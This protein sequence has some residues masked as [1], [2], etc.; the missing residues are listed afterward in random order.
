MNGISVSVIIAT[1]NTAE[2]LDECLKSIVIQTL[3]DIEVI[4]V[5]DGSTDN[6]KEIIDTYLKK[7]RNF[8]YMYKENAGAGLARNDGIKIAQGEYL[9]F[10]DPDDKYPN[11]ESLEKL[12]RMAKLKNADICGGN[13]ISFNDSKKWVCYKAGDGSDKEITD[14]VI[15]AK[16]YKY[17]YG[18]QRYFYKTEFVKKHNIFFAPYRR[19]EDQ[20]FTVK[21]L[22]I[23]QKLY[24]IDY[25]VYLYRT[26]YKEIIYNDILYADILKGYRDTIELL[27]QYELKEMFFANINS[28]TYEIKQSFVNYNFISNR[29][30]MNIVCEINAI[31]NKTEWVDKD[32]I[33]EKVI[34]ELLER[35]ELEKEKIRRIF[36]NDA[37]VLY[38]AGK[39]TEKLLSVLDENQR[40]KIK[41]IAVSSL[42]NNTVCINE[43]PVK[44]ICEYYNKKETVTIVVTPSIKFKTE[45]C[46]YLE[47]NGFE[48]FVWIDMRY[49]F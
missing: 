48:K 5:D 23:A 10:M 45:I 34:K 18:H 16:D 17:L 9:A 38:G 27:Y 8:I 22:G 1:Y 43:I 31:I 47:D 19:Y 33:S 44:S 30:I 42:D 41:G 36:L 28:I 24:E 4:I 39:N 46:D 6:S 49:I 40:K 32:I 20:V 35:V 2:Y 29:E 26:N 37:V 21:A 13:I 14:G 7:Y 3:R 15:E 12:Y 11:C 25:P